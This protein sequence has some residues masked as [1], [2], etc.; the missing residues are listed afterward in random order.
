MDKND[1]E[2]TVNQYIKGIGHQIAGRDFIKQVDIH[3]QGRDPIFDPKDPNVIDCPFGCGQK[4]WYHAQT[5]RNCDQ[6]VAQYFEYQEQLERQRQSKRF[7]MKV[8]I[9]MNT[10]AMVV[11][12]YLINLSENVLAN[13]FESLL[14]MLG[15]LIIVLSTV[16][17]F[18]QAIKY[19]LTR[20]D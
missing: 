2:T 9:A 5:C 16:L 15:Y 11:G 20:N 3:T 18:F 1:E 12:L 10:I 6:P 19:W 7:G 13:A 8:S 4:T 14:S 17:N